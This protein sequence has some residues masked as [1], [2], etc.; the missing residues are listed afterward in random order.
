MRYFILF[1]FVSQFTFAQPNTEVYLFDLNTNNGK[2]ELSNFRNISNNEGYDNQPSFLDDNTILFASTRKGQTDIARYSINYKSKVWINYTEGSEYS[3]L[4]IPNERAVSA[5]RL[6]KDGAQKLYKYNLSNGE[7]SV[8][9]EDIIIGYHRWFDQHTLVSSVLEDDALALYV[10]HFKDRK[11]H[12]LQKS[13]GRSLHKIP[14]TSL[15]SYVSKEN[16]DLWEIKSLDPISG[17][18][19]ALTTTLPKSEDLC[20]LPNGTILM[21]NE[22]TL[23]TYTPKKSVDWKEVSSLKSYNIKNITRLAVS[24]DGTKLAVVAES[25]EA[26]QTQQT[27]TTT[28]EASTSEADPGAIVQ[29]H[30]EPFNNRDLDGFVNAFSE[31]VIV[32]IFPDQVRYQGRDKLKADYIDYYKNVK[33]ST[34]KVLNRIT[35]KNYVIDEELGTDGQRTNRK[36]TFYTTGGDK[37]KTMTFMPN[38]RTTTNPE[39]IVNKQLYAYNTRNIDA[40]LAT[41]TE[42][43]KLYSYP[44]KALSTGTESMRTQYG[45]MFDNIPDLNAEIVNR[46]VLGNKVIDKEKVTVNGRTF[47]AVA[48]YEVKDGLINKVTFIQ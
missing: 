45:S 35:H 8:L 10:T 25:A 22:D 14:N 46:I 41:Y 1:V 31:D 42:D 47:Y 16:P 23:Y 20:W 3:P 29:R 21:G 7:S 28:T 5:I 19:T 33:K 17:V 13:I 15:V 9:V 27:E 32:S 37:I 18:T 6:E 36:V 43:V 48:I 40:F 2:F 26:A 44:A 30:I 39:A 12:K 24:P 11:N 38:S 34:V 4:K